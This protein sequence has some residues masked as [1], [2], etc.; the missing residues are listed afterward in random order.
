M[1]EINIGELMLKMGCQAKLASRALAC[2]STQQKNQA[3]EGIADALLGNRDQLLVA[4]Q[5]DV[6]LAKQD[7][8]AKSM[9]ERLAL[10]EITIERIAEGVR[11][12]I[13]LPDPIGEIDNL[14]YRPS[15]IKVGKMRMPLGVVAIIYEARPNV[16]ADAAAL[17]L[18]SGNATI[19]RGGKNAFYSNQAISNCLKIGLAKAKLPKDA[20]Q[21]LDTTDRLAV[22]HLV[23]MIQYVDV[24]VIRGG[25]GLIESV[26]S[27][28]HIPVIKHLDGI[29][30]VYIDQYADPDKA[31]A[32]AINAKTQRYS[33]CNTM[34]TLLV[35]A[36]IA[37]TILPKLAKG[38]WKKNVALHGCEKTCVLL[39][40]KVI[41]AKIH[42]WST[43]YLAPILSIRIVSDLSEAID[44]IHTF[45]S[46]HTDSIVTENYSHAQR[47]LR[48]VDSASVMVNAS[49]RLSDGF[50]YGLGAEIGISTDKIHARGPVGLEGLTSQKWIVLG[51]GHIRS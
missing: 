46:L 37:P 7:G 51:N 23:K 34:E 38:F 18:K 2:A 12:I 6:D 22:N 24:A 17:C 36:D 30:H 45:G 35:Q 48:E 13:S 27:E 5:R 33:A 14:C 43:E 42:D 44:H 49:T 16:T 1:I 8:V 10:N 29:C 3:L 25:R 4:N 9:I 31:F 32:I 21:V 40:E 28:A 20:I 19:L 11:Q 26:C 39:G 50:E 15:G 41:A 47:F